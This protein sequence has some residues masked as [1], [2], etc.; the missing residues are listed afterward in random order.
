[1]KRRN[2]LGFLGG[3]AVGG[4]QV[5]AKA[6]ES[7]AALSLPDVAIKTG[8]LASGSAGIGGPSI[9]PAYKAMRVKQIAKELMGFRK[10]KSKLIEEARLQMKELVGFRK[11][12]SKLIEEARLQM[13]DSPLRLEPDLHS[14]RSMSLTR[15]IHIQRD[16]DLLRQ[17]NRQKSWLQR[18]LD[19]LMGA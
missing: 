6:I 13:H 12:K 15:K 2:F 5:A 14:L 3:A 4:K 1:M 7:A 17:I 8:V 18:E 16:A 10:S 19:Q 11:S 9:D